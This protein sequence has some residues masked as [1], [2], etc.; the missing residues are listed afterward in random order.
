[1]KKI[2]TFLALC[3]ATTLYTEA[4]IWRVNNNP[5]VNANFTDLQPAHNA[6]ANGDTI[7][8]E[9][10]NTNYGSIT[11]TKR[12]TL[13]G[14]GYFLTQ[15][16]GKQDNQINARI[17]AVTF[18]DAYATNNSLISTSAGSVISGLET[19]LITTRVSNITISRCKAAGIQVM[20]GNGPTGLF[21]TSNILIYQNFVGTISLSNSTSSSP[22]AATNVLIKNNITYQGTIIVNYPC[23]AI[24]ENNT[25]LMEGNNVITTSNSTW[26]S[27]IF[28][29]NNP[30]TVNGYFS[31]PSNSVLSHNVSNT[32]FTTA[33][34]ATG[35]SYSS[36][37]TNAN[38]MAIFVAD[39]ST[40]SGRPPVG[41]T[42]DNRFM[43]KAGSPAIGAGYN[44]VNAGAFEGTT[45]YILS[46]IPAIPSIY[47]LEVPTTGQ[48]SLNVKVSIRS[49]Q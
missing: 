2:F 31:T 27:N 40:N 30:I 14:A 45:P 22:S 48:N 10:S 34:N 41:F 33:P 9:P 25:L 16:T 29:A 21:T 23:S 15:N 36:N 4:K 24:I 11:L 1:M 12:L 18:D 38:T 5:G 28:I 6:A 46:G 39:P 32:T 44:G 13:Y 26:R 43:L 35:I 20:D 42:D 47:Y 49:N 8:V 7:I 17:G 37:V 19:G 3:A